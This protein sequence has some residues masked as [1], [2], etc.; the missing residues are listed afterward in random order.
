[1]ALRRST[2]FAQSGAEKNASDVHTPSNAE[3]NAAEA[4]P[5]QS[6]TATTKNNKNGC[7]L[8]PNL[9]NKQKERTNRFIAENVLSFSVGLSLEL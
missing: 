2:L 5:I 6:Q 9:Y 1:L 7:E 8:N 4:A 3:E